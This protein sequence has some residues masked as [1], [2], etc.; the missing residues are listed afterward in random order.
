MFLDYPPLR[1]PHS[2]IFFCLCFCSFF[3]SLSLSISLSLRTKSP[4]FPWTQTPVLLLLTRRRA[5]RR[6]EGRKR[7]ES[8]LLCFVS[9]GMNQSQQGLSPRSIPGL[10]RDRFPLCSRP[11]SLAAARQT[12]ALLVEG[13][14][15]RLVAAEAFRLAW[16]SWW[17]PRPAMWRF[18][19]PL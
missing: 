17:R 1:L 8:Q 4:D 7:Q 6:T 16:G 18:P 10:V 12:A 5:G 3:L 13:A 14:T 15:D 11:S 9:L 19:S 2:L